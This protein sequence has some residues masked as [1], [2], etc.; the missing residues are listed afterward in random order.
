MLQIQI[1]ELSRAQESHSSHIIELN[2]LKLQYAPCVC[3]FVVVFMHVSVSYLWLR[4]W[5]PPCVLVFVRELCSRVAHM[6]Q[7]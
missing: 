1:E 4:L 7:T 3:A 6:N 2:T 5:L